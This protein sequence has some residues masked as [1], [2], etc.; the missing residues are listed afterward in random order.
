MNQSINKCDFQS[1]D[2]GADG[3]TNYKVLDDPRRNRNSSIPNRSAEGVYSCIPDRIL[4]N[5][6]NPDYQGDGWYRFQGEK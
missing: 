4:Y 3:C 5:S 6:D 1:C 2:S